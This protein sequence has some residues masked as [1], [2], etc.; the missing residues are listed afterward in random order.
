ML[1]NGAVRLSV[2]PVLAHKSRM[3]ARRNF[4]FGGNML[5]VA[6][7]TGDPCSGRK[8]QRSYGPVKI[9]NRRRF[10]SDYGQQNPQ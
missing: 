9:L 2:R 1:Q 8:G 10:A 3:K 7:L 4:E 5:P 6:Q